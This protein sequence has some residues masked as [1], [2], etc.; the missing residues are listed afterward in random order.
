MDHFRN[1]YHHKAVEYHHMIDAEDVD[2]NLKP[3]TQSLL[4]DHRHILDMG[5]GTGRF[6]LL[7]HSTK[8]E[9]TGMDLHL[10]ML[11]ENKRQ[12][13]I[14]GGSWP[15]LCC[16]MR[17]LPFPSHS[18]DAAVAGWAIGHL[19]AWYDSD[20]ENQIGSVIA[21]MGRVVQ[22]GGALVILETLGTGFTS[23]QPPTSALAE[24][25]DKLEKDW[26]F[27]RQAI[28]TDYFFDNV[29]DAVRRTTFF[30]GS[31]LAEKVTAQNWQRLPEWTGIWSKTA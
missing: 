31:E 1:I 21:E 12:R 30:F 27:N 5:T 20:W 13:S 2:G 10:A 14:A 19:R 18:W 24:Y 9:I 16:D 29:D 15:L 6:P 4:G 3:A 26:G 22:P 23:P 11:L 8:Y 28:Q 17:A 7:L 25:Y